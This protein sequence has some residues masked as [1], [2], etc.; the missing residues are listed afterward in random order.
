[1][2]LVAH[3][4]GSQR[5]YCMVGLTMSAP[6]HRILRKLGAPSRYNLILSMKA[7]QEEREMEGSR[8]GY[9]R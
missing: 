8:H 1:M 9:Q 5:S 2:K 7:Q 6:M 4:M 3:P